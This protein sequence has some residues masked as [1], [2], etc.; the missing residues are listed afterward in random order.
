VTEPLDVPDPAA[1]PEQAR[2]LR[3][4]LT[5]HAVDTRPLAIAPYRRLLVG[6]GT[7]FIGSMLTQVAVPVQIWA[8]TAS[9]LY[10]GF[11]G[12]AGLVPIVVFGLYGGA[13]ADAVDRRVLYLWSSIGGWVVTLA[14]LVQTLLDLQNIWLILA[15]VFVQSG[16]FAVAWFKASMLSATALRNVARSTL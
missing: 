1:G 5:R 7:S 2:T 3:R 9:P 8:L 13:I 11:V 6:Q 16:M 14:L 4:L 10:V 12:L 15:L